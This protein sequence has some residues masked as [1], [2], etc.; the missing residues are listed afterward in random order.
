MAKE[1]I[2]AETAGEETIIVNLIDKKILVFREI[3]GETQSNLISNGDQ[4]E[5]S[6]GRIAVEIKG[7]ST[8]TKIL[9]GEISTEKKV[10]RT[11]ESVRIIEIIP[12]KMRDGK[13]ISEKYSPHALLYTPIRVDD[14]TTYALIDT[15]AS[16]RAMSKYFFDRL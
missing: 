12:H 4:I 16:V 10:N 3:I 13:L 7:D 2:S 1:A 6:Q 9:T 14:V 5:I 8:K 15:E 11:K